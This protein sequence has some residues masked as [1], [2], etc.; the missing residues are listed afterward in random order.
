MKPLHIGQRVI[1]SARHSYGPGVVAREPEPTLLG[2]PPTM[3]WIKFDADGRYGPRKVLIEHLTAETGVPP[4]SKPR[5]FDIP[6]SGAVR[7]AAVK[8]LED[9]L[10]ERRPGRPSSVRGLN[11]VDG[12]RAP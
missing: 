3:A 5:T 10:A 6:P 1:H 9:R 11:V 8:V 12:G 7:D 2:Q 4:P